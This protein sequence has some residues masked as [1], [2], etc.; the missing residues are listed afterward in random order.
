MSAVFVGLL[1]LGRLPDAGLDVAFGS[2]FIACVIWAVL[3]IPVRNMS[4]I[5]LFGKFFENRLI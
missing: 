2:F 4:F 5:A 3:A 1:V